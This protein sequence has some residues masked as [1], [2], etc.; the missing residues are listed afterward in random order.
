MAGE[1]RNLN[2]ESTE[3]RPVRVHIDNVYKKYNTRNG[4]VVALNGVSLDIH[5]NACSWTISAGWRTAHV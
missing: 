2:H 1:A 4:E 5:E 3:S